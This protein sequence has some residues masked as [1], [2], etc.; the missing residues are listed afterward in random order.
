VP[1][2]TL[3]ACARLVVLAQ[4]AV[5]QGNPSAFTDAAA[6]VHLARAAAEI[7]SYNV[8]VNLADVEDEA[9]VTECRREVKERFACVEGL[10]EEVQGHASSR[11]R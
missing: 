6:A 3:R 11:L 9:F 5:E 1:L 8:R 7:A 2:E 10:V 4:A